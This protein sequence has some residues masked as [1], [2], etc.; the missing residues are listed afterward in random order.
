L[1]HES[2]LSFLVVVYISIITVVLLTHKLQGLV[3]DI[4][5]SDLSKIDAVMGL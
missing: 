3:Q 5:D 1:Q 2:F 4:W